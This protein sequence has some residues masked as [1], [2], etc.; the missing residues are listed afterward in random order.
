VDSGSPPRRSMAYLSVRGGRRGGRASD[1][2]RVARKKSRDRVGLRRRRSE[3][4]RGG[5]VRARR[6]RASR[7]TRRAWRAS[8]PWG[9]RRSGGTRFRPPEAVATRIACIS[10]RARQ[11][12][13]P[14]PFRRTT[15]SHSPT[16]RVSTYVERA[17]WR[18]AGVGFQ[19]AQTVRRRGNRRLRTRA[20]RFTPERAGID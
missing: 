11:G 6:V 14:A 7:R 8:S 4:G 13:D 16:T 20:R 9:S 15:S 10:A 17:F 19:D 12:S 5:D 18:S 2:S 3:N 1:V